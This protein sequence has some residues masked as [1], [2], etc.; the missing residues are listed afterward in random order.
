MKNIYIGTSDG[1]E[2]THESDK[3]PPCIWQ[4]HVVDELTPDQVKEKLV[5]KKVN[6][7]RNSYYNSIHMF[8]DDFED[9][10]REKY[11]Y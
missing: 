7:L 3:I 4:T 8:C 5:C 10:K 2:T 11:K 1:V 6:Q 9:F